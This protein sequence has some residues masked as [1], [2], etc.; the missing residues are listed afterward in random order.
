MNIKY[1]MTLVDIELE[2]LNKTISTI[3]KIGYSVDSDDDLV[4]NMDLIWMTCEKLELYTRALRDKL[5]NG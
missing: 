3:K 5:E 4:Y 2:H 1:H